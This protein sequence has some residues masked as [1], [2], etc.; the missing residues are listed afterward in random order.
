[1]KFKI[2]A[3]MVMV[4]VCQLSALAVSDLNVSFKC[5]KYTNTRT[6]MLRMR[7]NGPDTIPAGTRLYYYY[8]TPNEQTVKTHGFNAANDLPKGKI[9]DVL[10]PAPPSTQVSR[11]G[12]S[13]KEI[14]VPAELG[15]RPTDVAP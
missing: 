3:C 2:F 1:M 13:L 8:Y 11:C 10:V 7:N 9:F 5:G 12:C 6:L 14:K 4:L 15:P